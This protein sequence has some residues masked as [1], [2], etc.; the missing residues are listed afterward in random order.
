MPR[1]GSPGRGVR[2]AR[3]TETSRE[4]GRSPLSELSLH[5]QPERGFRRPTRS[6]Q[7]RRT[8]HV[9][10]AGSKTNTFLLAEPMLF[11]VPSVSEPL[12]GRA[13]F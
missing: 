5:S 9:T 3:R 10:R 7:P 8:S 11:V 12:P 13:A 2:E 6:S 4:Q 1:A